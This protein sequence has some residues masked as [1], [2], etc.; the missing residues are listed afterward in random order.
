M[1][2]TF[3]PPYLLFSDV[4][5]HNWSS[6]SYITENLM[7]SRLVYQIEEL[8][9]AYEALKAEG[10][11]LAVCAGDLF[12]VR[13]KL[14]PSVT[15]PVRDFFREMD[16]NFETV[17]LSGN[18][19][20]E[21]ADA[22]EL[23][24]AVSV[25][26]SE[27]TVAINDACI[28]SESPG[29]YMIPWRSDLGAL[30]KEIKAMSDTLASEKSGKSYDLIIHAPMNEV[31]INIPNIGLNASEFAGMSFNRVFAGHYHNHKRL[32]DNVWSVGATGHQ[33]WND[34]GTQAGWCLVYEDEV[35][36]VASRQPQFV[37]IP[38]GATEEDVMEASGHFVR[39]D[40]LDPTPEKI[41]A[42]REYLKSQ[43]VAGVTI[44]AMVGKK[45][46]TRDGDETV[47]AVDSLTVAINKFAL[48]KHSELVA[49]EC[50]KIHEEV[51]N[52]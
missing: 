25:I 51:V 20:L 11:K 22:D 36:F 9:R 14:A 47:S 48:E 33:T 24:S 32:A 40:M 15:N 39:A 6:F 41:I 5:F 21:G 31:L 8:R 2:T 27:K 23:T 19:D 38:V 44:R 7:N 1:S 29:I 30:R 35:K 28:A 42:M 46:S 18:H 17:I 37:K 34:P 13:G 12:H 52:A 3:K 43:G 45:E 10:G 16:E 4:H 50:A 49:V 26:S